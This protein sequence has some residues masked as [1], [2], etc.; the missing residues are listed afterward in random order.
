MIERSA[1]SLS[2]S[3]IELTGAIN[4]LLHWRQPVNNARKLPWAARPLRGTWPVPQALLCQAPAACGVL[5]VI[6]H[7]VAEDTRAIRGQALPCGEGHWPLRTGAQ[8]AWPLLPAGGGTMLVAC[9]R[10]L[11]Y[12]PIAGLFHLAGDAGARPHGRR[13]LTHSWV[14]RRT[15]PCMAICERSPPAHNAPARR[16]DVQTHADARPT[17][18][19]CRF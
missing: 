5:R 11:M 7:A 1:A 15:Q 14:G 18:G 17:T 12:R 13:G 19:L 6:A 2:H 8:H 16:W 10:P 3:M 9:C 4:K